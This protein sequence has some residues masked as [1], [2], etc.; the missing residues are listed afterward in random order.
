LKHKK[1]LLEI[2]DSIESKPDKKIHISMYGN[3][4]EFFIK[5]ISDSKKCNCKKSVTIRK[6]HNFNIIENHV[7]FD[8]TNDEN[9]KKCKCVLTKSYQF[10]KIPPWIFV[11]VALKSNIKVDALPDTLLINDLTY[12]FIFAIIFENNPR[13]FR[14]IFK[15]NGC[16]Y[17]IDDLGSTMTKDL[18][19]SSNSVRGCF[20]YLT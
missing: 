15:L 6:S 16:F 3:Q 14:G 18:P 4:Y 13:H 9:C 2:I 10:I 12:Q 17:L 1:E 8:L 7:N 19:S 20:Y 11:D 5:I